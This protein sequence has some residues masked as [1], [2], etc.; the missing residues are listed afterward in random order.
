M[1]L[2]NKAPRTGNGAMFS[3]IGPQKPI[4]EATFGSTRKLQRY[5]G[6][7]RRRKGFLVTKSHMGASLSKNP[8]HIWRKS[9]CPQ[10]KPAKICEN[11]TV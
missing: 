6:K 7:Q 3:L 10:R 11:L 2:E 8:V 9:F 4:F 1:A 5:L